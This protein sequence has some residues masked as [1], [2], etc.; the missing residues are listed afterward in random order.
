MTLSLNDMADVFRET[1]PDQCPS[2]FSSTAVDLIL[3]QLTARAK[4]ME[5]VVDDLRRSLSVQE[6]V[7]EFQMSDSKY[8]SLMREVTGQM[9]ATVLEVAISARALGI[10][11]DDVLEEYHDATL[12]GSYSSTCEMPVDWKRYV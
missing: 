4:V 5:H 2:G 6:N 8:L 9:C 7:K 11:L 12:K 10:N 3:K 1:K